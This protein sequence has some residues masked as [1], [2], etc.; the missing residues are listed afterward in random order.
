MSRA[1]RKGASNKSKII[2]LALLVILIVSVVA[3]VLITNQTPILPTPSPSSFTSSAWMS[4]VPANAQGFEFLNLSF[5]YA[6]YPSLFT[7]N[8]I[9]TLDQ[10]AL[11]IT[12]QEVNYEVLTTINNE[13]VYAYSIDSTD[14][15]NIAGSLATANLTYDVYNNVTLYQINATGNMVWACIVHG[16]LVLTNDSSSISELALQSVVDSTQTSFFNNDSLKSGYLLDWEGTSTFAFSYEQSG[17]NTYNLNWAMLSLTSTSVV[18]ER[19]TLNFPSSSVVSS[20]F[21]TAK[22]NLFPSGTSIYTSGSF[23]VGDYGFPLT[24]QGLG[25]ALES[26]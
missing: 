19:I 11:N 21:N 1:K 25:E 14:L 2:L 26:I 18:N 16:G 24:Q 7:S 20:E 8:L 22:S 6:S 10:P 17:T 3:A 5:L 13:G 4:F 15:S 9:R 12:V 23:L